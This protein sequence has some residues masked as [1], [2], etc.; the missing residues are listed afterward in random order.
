MLVAGDHAIN[1]MASDE[2]DSW[3]T[4]IQKAGIVAEP[5]VQGLGENPLIRQMFVDH[6]AA[7]EL[8]NKPLVKEKVA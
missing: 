7:T 8:A 2:P 4:L 1:D 3:K 6:L 5:I